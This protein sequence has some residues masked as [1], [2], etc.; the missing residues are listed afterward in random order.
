MVVKGV[1]QV[2]DK[3]LA[4]AKDKIVDLTARSMANNVTISGLTGDNDEENPKQK[5]LTFM[6]DLMKMTLDDAEV[7]VAHRMGK[8]SNQA[9]NK[10]RLMVVRC[11]QSLKD[12]IFQYTSNL[13]GKTNDQKDYYFV[14][15]QLPEPLLPQK[16]ERETQLKDIKQANK[17]IP[18]NEADKRTK[19]YIKNKT[20]YIGGKPQIHHIIPPTA[21]D[22]FNTTPGEHSKQ[23]NLIKVMF[24]RDML[25]MLDQTVRSNK[26]TRS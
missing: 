24:F 15:S 18:D 13:K 23:K 1:I 5:V 8:K 14:K 6:R 22:L 9:T 16:I 26:S 12:R 11:A 19:A 3:S 21:V 10:P 20:L 25:H 2:H 17:L 4:S 7:L